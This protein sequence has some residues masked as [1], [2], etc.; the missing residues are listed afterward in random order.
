[1]SGTVSN[2][3]AGVVP[4]TVAGLVASGSV[5]AVA[6]DVVDVT[7]SRIAS[8]SSSSSFWARRASIPVPHSW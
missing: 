5:V 6:G 4:D 2:E 3:A 8:N 1:V 7:E